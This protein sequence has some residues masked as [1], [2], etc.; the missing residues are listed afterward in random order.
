MHH[1]IKPAREREMPHVKKAAPQPEDRQSNH[2][3]ADE[4]TERHALAAVDTAM[5]QLKEDS[6]IEEV[7]LAPMNSFYR[8]I[9]HQYAVD[10]GYNSCSVGDGQE[11]GV[12]VS[13]KS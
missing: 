8:R 5:Q 13:R 4:D 12:K 11:R 9:Q 7:F 3:P 2:S 10:Q 1:E 6:G